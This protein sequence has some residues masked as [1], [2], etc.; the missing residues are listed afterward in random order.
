MSHCLKNDVGLN[1]ECVRSD[2]YLLSL[3]VTPGDPATAITTVLDLISLGKLIPDASCVSPLRAHQ[4]DEMQWTKVNLQ[5]LIHVL[6]FNCALWTPRTIPFLWV[7]STTVGKNTQKNL[8]PKFHTGKLILVWR[9]WS[10]ETLQSYLPYFA[11][12]DSDHWLE[13]DMSSSKICLPDIPRGDRHTPVANI[14]AKCY[15]S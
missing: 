9:Q 2:R 8:D 10:V 1:S 3:P 11:A 7:Q 14:N 15:Y 5:E 13:A 6:W 4:G 12:V